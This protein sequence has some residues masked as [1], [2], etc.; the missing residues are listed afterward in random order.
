MLVLVMKSK[1]DFSGNINFNHVVSKLALL[2]I[3]F[4]RLRLLWCS[5]P[6]NAAEVFQKFKVNFN[7]PNKEE[8]VTKGIMG[9]QV[10]ECLYS[11]KAQNLLR[12]MAGIT[13]QNIHHVM[14]KVKNIRDLVNL[15]LEDM[16]KLIGPAGVYLYDFCNKAN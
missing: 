16:K 3:H 7:Q 13:A 1:N 8:A 6:H 11:W 9:P 10:D 4:P 5:N 15:S 12:C 14:N 2:T